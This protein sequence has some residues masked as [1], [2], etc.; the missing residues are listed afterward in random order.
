M[1]KGTPMKTT[2]NAYAAMKPKGKLAEF[3]YTLEDLAPEEVEVDIINCGICHSD[4]S[5]LDHEWGMT[6]YPI[7]PGHEAI[8]VIT[9][10]GEQVKGLKIGQTV[11]LGWY[12]S[13][14]LHCDPCLQGDH[15][16]CPSTTQT[17][18]GHHGGFADKMRCHWLWAIPLPD[19][20]DKGSSGPLFCGGITVFNPIVQHGIKPTDRVG[21]IGIGGLGHMAIQFLNKWGC[22]VTAFTSTDAKAEEAKTLGAHHVVNSR[23]TSD[24][25]K[26]EGSLDFILSTVNANLNWPAY[27]STLKPKGIFHTVGVIPDP[28]SIPAFQLISGQK[29]IAGSPLGSP[30]TIR[31][32]LEFCGRHQIK[33]HVEYFPMSEVNNAI[34]H[35]RSG[36]ARY[37]V[38]LTR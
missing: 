3:T 28:I 34:D 17:I 14:C 13:S 26:I 20:L 9:K 18:V 12:A 37:R 33:P 35:L 15:N 8:G 7:V 1:K 11:G 24:L 27:V 32:M 38:V 31:K 29:S 4:L 10:M 6:T 5:M 21:V 23:N 2:V 22:D 36:D 16:L 30:A 19:T 25:G